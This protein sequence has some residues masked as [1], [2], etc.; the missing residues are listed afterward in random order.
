MN[1]LRT[2]LRK[3]GP[4]ATAVTALLLMGT[5]WVAGV[6]HHDDAAERGCAIC[7]LSH[8]SATTTVAAAEPTPLPTFEL[9][10]DRPQLSPHTPRLEAS[11]GR[12]PPS[13]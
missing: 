10:L 3:C 12:G 5:L 9:L 7:T 2:L 11:P 4:L 8:T 1:P 6:H 13:V